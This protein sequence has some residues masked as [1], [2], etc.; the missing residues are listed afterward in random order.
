MTV[1]ETMARWV[2][3][4]AREG[5]D[6]PAEQE[7]RRAL[8]NILGTS[9]SGSRSPD[10][11]RMMRLGRADGE[12]ASV[13]VPG[14]GV[15]TSLYL[16]AMMT[17]FAAHVDDFDDTHLASGNM[18]VGSV[19]LGATFGLAQTRA[20]SGRAFLAAFAVVCETLIRIGEAL[21]PSHH[22]AGW[23]PNSTCGP[24][25][26]ALG[27]GMLL[28]LDEAALGSAAAMASAWPLGQREA[29]GTPAK[30]YHVARACVNGVSAA[31]MAG[32]GVRVDTGVWE[33]DRGAALAMAD[34]VDARKALEGLGRTWRLR[35]NTYK[36][37]PCGVV[38][39]PGIDAALEASRGIL[40]GDEVTG[41]VYECHPLVLELMDRPVPSNGLEARF[42]AQHAVACA[43]VRGGM[44]LEELTEEAVTDADLAQVRSLVTLHPRSDFD[45]EE[46]AVTI[47]RVDGSLL[48]GRVDSPRGSTRRPLTDAELNEKASR[49]ARPVLGNKAR[50]IPGAVDELTE[51]ASVDSLITALT[52]ADVDPACVGA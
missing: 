7:A 38:S 33:A 13:W 24:I 34:A 35:S 32:Q 14:L 45:R 27:A 15:R 1:L 11:Q 40:R 10:V 31:G 4:V 42:S 30:A 12:T 26:A 29:L 3:Q 25:A 52:P 50:L 16:G 51:Q 28:G 20:A 18:H 17:G 46:A 9:V 41:V 44:S 8:L 5:L 2:S 36:A 37:Y 39:H 19:A 43:V 48:R 47:Q 49:L 6:P 23:Q 22:A 21:A